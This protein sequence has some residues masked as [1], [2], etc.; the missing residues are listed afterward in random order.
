MSAESPADTYSW[1]VGRFTARMS[2]LR[3]KPSKVARAVIEW[4]PHMPASLTPDELEQ[5]RAGRDA[6]LNSLRITVLVVET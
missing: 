1:S 5:Y 2:V 3:V 4:A 6:A